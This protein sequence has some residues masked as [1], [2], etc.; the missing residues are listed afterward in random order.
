MDWNVKVVTEDNYVKDVVVEDYIYPDDAVRAALSQTGAKTFISYSSV[1]DKTDTSSSNF[2]NVEYIQ[3]LGQFGP[4]Y[5][6]TDQLQLILLMILGIITFAFIP[7]LAI[8]IAI[9]FFYKVIKVNL[10]SK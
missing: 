4:Q 6:N 5:N 3:E 2:S 8:L 1:V 9:A 7:P 10:R